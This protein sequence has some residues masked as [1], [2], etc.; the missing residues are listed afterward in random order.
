M[1]STR[2]KQI[3]KKFIPSALYPSAVIGAEI[4]RR[5]RTQVIGGPFAGMHFV[6]KALWGAYLPKLLGTYEKEVHGVLDYVR[7][8]SFRRVVDIG[9]AEG[10]Y[11]VGLLTMLPDAH[12]TVFETLPAGRAMIEELAELNHVRDRLSIAG[13]CDGRALQSVLAGSPGSFVLCD[14]EGYE[15]ELLDPSIINALK[16]QYLLVEIHDHKSPGCSTALRERF[17]RTHDVQEI[18]QTPHTL[19]DYPLD[20][21][22]RR[23]WPTGILRYA[24]NEFRD[25]QTAWLWITPKAQA[26]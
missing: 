3:L 10:F 21:P 8:R 13:A 19:D 7:A 4:R 2:K 5:T 12:V 24:L 11:A 22:I 20:D 25:P 15:H 6:E 23:Y 18:R 17:E 16:T 14:V 9:G 1:I 26:D